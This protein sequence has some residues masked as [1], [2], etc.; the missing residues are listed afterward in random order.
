MMDVQMPKGVAVSYDDGP[1]SWV[2]SDVA[3]QSISASSVNPVGCLCFVPHDRVVYCTY[4]SKLVAVNKQ[5]FAK[6]MDTNP[7]DPRSEVMSERLCFI[8][9]ATQ[10]SGWGY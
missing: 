5:S 2:C 1:G 10:T 3:G 9:D 8:D 7:M 6:I 4:L